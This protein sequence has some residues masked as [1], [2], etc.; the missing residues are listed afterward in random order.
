MFLRTKITPGN[1]KLCVHVNKKGNRGQQK[2]EE[3]EKKAIKDG[4]L[5]FAFLTAGRVLRHGLTVD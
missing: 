3:G 2:A 5:I 4:Q 1:K